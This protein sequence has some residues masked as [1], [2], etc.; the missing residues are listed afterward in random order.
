M[1]RDLPIIVVGGVDFEGKRG[2]YSQGVGDEIASSAVGS[3]YCPAGNGDGD[4]MMEGTS[5]GMI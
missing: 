2:W 1:F 3:V 5:F 4:Q